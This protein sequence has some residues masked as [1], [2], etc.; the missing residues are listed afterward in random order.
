MTKTSASIEHLD[1]PLP[2]GQP[3]ATCEICG[4]PATVRLYRDGAPRA[5]WSCED[6]LDL[7]SAKMGGATLVRHLR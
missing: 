1:L 7:A 5:T 3:S 2:P 6:C 4:K